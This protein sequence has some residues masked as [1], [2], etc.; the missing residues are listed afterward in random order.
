GRRVSAFTA[1]QREGYKD[2]ARPNRIIDEGPYA[3]AT[4]A[5]YPNVEHVVVRNEG[6]SPLAYLDRKF[7]LLDR[8][9]R[10]ICATGGSTSMDNATRKRKLRV[11]LEGAFGN[12]GISYDGMELLPELFRS[13]RWLRL[14]WE[15]SAL[16]ASR[17]MRWR[18]VLANTFGPWCPPVLW[19]LVHKIAGKH[20]DKVRDYTTI[21][22]RRFGELDLPTRARARNHDLVYRPWKD[23]FAMRLHHLQYMDPGNY[24]K[25]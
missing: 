11:I 10:G 18:G 22:P 16:V 7:F 24:N 19:D 25:G 9:V 15:A 8:P 2:P 20:T 5:L 17:R 3:A 1:A 12:L 4:A 6:R 13:G 14:W 23:G 21:P